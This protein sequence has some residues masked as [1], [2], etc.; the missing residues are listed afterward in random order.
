MAQLFLEI[1]WSL[2]VL[3]AIYL[4][5]T[6]NHQILLYTFNPFSN[7]APEF[8][9]IVRKDTFTNDSW[10]LLEHRVNQSSLLM[11]REY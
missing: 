5:E 8:W 3:S 7:L 9:H 1:A 10:T 11:N 2:N 6:I 4:C